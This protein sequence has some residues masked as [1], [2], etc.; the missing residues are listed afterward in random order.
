[1]IFFLTGN[2]DLFNYKMVLSLLFIT[3][4]GTS[5]G[6]KNLD[7]FLSSFSPSM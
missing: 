3:K 6:I 7:K 2:F 4:N 5:I 1:M